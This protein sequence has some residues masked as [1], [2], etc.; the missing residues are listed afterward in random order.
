MKMDYIKIFCDIN[1]SCEDKLK[2][3]VIIGLLQS[4]RDNCPLDDTVIN[5]MLNLIY[6]HKKSCLKNYTPLSTKEDTYLSKLFEFR[7]N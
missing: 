3:S 5:E 6:N 2:V 1:N 7:E 4:I